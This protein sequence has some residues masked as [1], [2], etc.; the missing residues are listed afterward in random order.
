VFL[1]FSGLGGLKLGVGRGLLGG[2]L[3]FAKTE[4]L[5]RV[6]H[7]RRLARLAQ[8]RDRIVARLGAVG[9]AAR[10]LDLEDIWRLHHELLNP[11]RARAGLPPPRVRLRETL[12][13][14]PTLRREGRHFAELTEAEQLAHEDIED[15]RGC[16]RQGGIFRRVNTLKV[17]PESG[18]TYFATES[19]LGLA[20]AAGPLPFTLAVT[21]HLRSQRS[22]RWLLDNQHALVQS[23][24][25]IMPFL[26]RHSVEQDE[27]D[28]SKREAIRGLFE[29]LS[30]MSS[31]IVALSVSLLLEG[32]TL[33][34]L[35]A[36]TEAARSAFAAAGNSELLAE[37][38]TQLPAFLSMLP[39]AGRYQ[40]RRKGCTSRNA[41]DFLPVFAVVAVFFLLAAGAMAVGVMFKRPCLRGSCGGPAVAG[42]NGEKLSC[43]T[44]PNRKRKAATSA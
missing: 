32:E 22:A 43:E 16:L 6:E 31:K 17:L 3:L 11:G 19:L 12:W 9:I 44:C 10:E 29:E 25:Q 1:F 21:V 33:D 23:L 34:A 27:A 38:V 2:R 40:L 41:A 26:E 28:R 5:T 4:D 24:R 36:A 42:P 14:E 7:E 13:S 30:S 35:D 18:T 20:T 39:G 37:E 8:L 15:E